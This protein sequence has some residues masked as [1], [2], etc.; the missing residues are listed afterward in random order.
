MKII[1]SLLLSVFCTLALAKV[2]VVIQTSV[3]DIEIELNDEKAPISVQNF[4]EY[5][6]NN[7]YP[8]T[9]V[10]RTIKNFVIQAGGILPDMTQKTPYAPIQNEATN[11]LSN[12]HGTISM[13][14]TN[15]IHSGSSHFFINTVDNIRLDHQPGN[16]N[17]YGYAV[18]GKVTAGL[19]VVDHIQNVATHTIGEYADVPVEPI[20]ILSVHRK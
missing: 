18:F 1:F 9:I 16:P 14:R 15:E 2:D 10:H 3:G 8:G 5:V 4:L 12:L 6:D 13:A 7:Y 11:G 17:K 19:E 20:L